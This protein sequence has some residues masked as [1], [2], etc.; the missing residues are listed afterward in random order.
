MLTLGHPGLISAPGRRNVN[1][2]GAVNGEGE[3]PEGIDGERVGAWLEAN[4]DG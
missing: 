3:A 4:V 1:R 2:V